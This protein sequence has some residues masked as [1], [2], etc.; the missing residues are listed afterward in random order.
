[1]KHLASILYVISGI[2]MLLGVPYA[3]MGETDLLVLLPGGIACFVIGVLCH[4]CHGVLNILEV[5]RNMEGQVA[6]LLDRLPRR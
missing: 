4:I 1:M 5:L 6:S 2:A 3:L